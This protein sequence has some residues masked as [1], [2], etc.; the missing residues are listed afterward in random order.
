M[1][2]G[3]SGIVGGLAGVPLAQGKGSEVERAQHETTNQERRVQGNTKA[4]DAAGV[5]ATDGEEHQSHER[6]ADGRRL[7]EAPVKGQQQP[8]AEAQSAERRSKDPHG[9]CGNQLDLSG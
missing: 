8:G 7:W 9:E 4:D 5:G 2:I 3:F 6:D 1:S